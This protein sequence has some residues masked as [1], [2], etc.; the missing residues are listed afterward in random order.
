LS[1]ELEKDPCEVCVDQQ[2]STIP[3]D[4]DG[5]HQNCPRCG[6]FK[7]SR[8]ANTIV[9]RLGKEKRAKLSGWILEQNRSGSLPMITTASLDKILSRPLPPVAE[10]ASSLLIEA[11]RVM[12]NLGDS[13]N[14]NDPKFLAATYSSNQKDVDFL[15]SMLSEQ[16]FAEIQAMGGHCR[17][18]PRGYI[19]LD[20][21]RKQ[22]PDSSRGFVAM[23]FHE[24]L[25]EIYST[26]FQLGIFNAG[27]DP[28]RMDQIE[29]VNRI[30]DEIIRQINASKFV[31]AD[32]TGHRGGVY[33]E[34]GYAMGLGIPVFWTCRKD[35]MDKLHFDIRQFNCIDWTTT[36]ELA[37]RLSVRLEAM[38]GA[39]P[40]KL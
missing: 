31:V 16:G 20:E 3:S 4:I 7:L 22:R 19:Q 6:E 30:D 21:M 40:N 13:F 14:I 36:E 35:D 11:E 1:V 24:D 18:L 27:Y 8:T 5:I 23:W 9:R 26:G 25:D 37:T 38:L 32:F 2:A 39:G 10:R 12:C 29:H 33:F 34:A 15:M 17:I 28:I